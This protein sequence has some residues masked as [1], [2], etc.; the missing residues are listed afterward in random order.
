MIDS[1]KNQDDAVVQASADQ[2]FF[3]LMTSVYI[4]ESGNTGETLGVNGRFNFSDQP[5]YVLAGV[6]SNA[7]ME[8]ELKIFVDSLRTKYRFQG[9]ELKAKNFYDR[10]P[11]VIAEVVEFVSQKRIPVFIEIM[12]KTFYLNIQ[13]VEYFLLPY[14]AFRLSDELIHKKRYIVTSLRKFLTQNVYEQL[15]VAVKTY[16]HE[17][18]ELFY[19][20]LIQ[21]FSSLKSD[22]GDV[23]SKSV[24]QTKI[25]FQEAKKQDPN[26]ALRKF[27]PLPDENPRKRL[28]HLLPNYPAF[29]NLVAR[30]ENYRN[31][32]GLTPINIIHDEQKQFDIIFETAFNQMKT[33]NTDK[34]T[35]GTIIKD[36]ATFNISDETKLSFEDSKSSY[37]IQI[38]DLIAGFVMRFWTDFISENYE[39]T[40][41]YLPVLTKL[42]YPN[43]GSSEGINFVVPDDKHFQ[44]THYH[45]FRRSQ[46]NSF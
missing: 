3:I 28:I 6:M 46:S 45:Q 5:Y 23:L 26:R 19:D 33:S 16:T 37:S 34:W 9:D 31:A 12:D 2:L 10:R 44:L 20:Q 22:E 43:D 41:L 1:A 17:S 7:M 38:A 21:H 27:L 29:T 25:D 39:K 24:Q 8:G 14:Y 30:A 36:T 13:L 42:I 35:H 40:D 18:L 11:K 4:D 15:F 32:K